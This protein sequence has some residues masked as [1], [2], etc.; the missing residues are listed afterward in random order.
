LQSTE[1]TLK[2][3]L[4]EEK[5][6]SNEQADHLKSL[7]TEV[8][9]LKEQI[10]YLDHFKQ[11]AETLKAKNEELSNRI[12]NV[13]EYQA[14]IATLQSNLAETEKK[15]KDESENVIIQQKTL[16]DV[17]EKYKTLEKKYREKIAEEKLL[18]MKLDL[19]KVHNQPP[20]FVVK[21]ISL[22][23]TPPQT[24]P[25]TT[26]WGPGSPLSMSEDSPTAKEEMRMYKAINRV[27]TTGVLNIR[28]KSNSDSPSAT[29]RGGKP[30]ESVPVP[31]SSPHKLG[32]PRV[33][34]TSAH[35]DWKRRQ[36]EKEKEVQERLALEQHK[37][38]ELLHLNNSVEEIS[39]P[40]LPLSEQHSSE[41]E[42]VRL[43]RALNKT[44]RKPNVGQKT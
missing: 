22:S 13:S 40:N 23:L 35:A 7:N 20:P 39:I 5:R 3:E 9:N 44:Q 29:P 15:L 31:P 2:N 43:S 37:K 18:N 28:S 10:T 19:E 4:E 17:Q 38:Q 1:I 30:P 6:R 14:T 41:I 27:P 11:E 26:P 32:T 8:I 33:S 34:G 25:T 12:Q 16:D 21:P 36:I 24:T 42:E